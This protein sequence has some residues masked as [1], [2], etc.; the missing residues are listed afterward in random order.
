MCVASWPRDYIVCVWPAPPP[1]LHNITFT[2]QN[3]FNLL[4]LSANAS[5]T[6]TGVV[7]SCASPRI[8][9]TRTLP[10]TLTYSQVQQCTSWGDPHI[11]TFD[12]IYYGF[13]LAGWGRP[14]MPAYIWRAKV[15]MGLFSPVPPS[16]CVASQVSLTLCEASLE[17]LWCKCLSSHVRVASHA[18]TLSS[19]SMAPR[20]WNTRQAQCKLAPCPRCS[21]CVRRELILCPFPLPAG[22]PPS[23]YAFFPTS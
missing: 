18:T 23:P 19:S 9:L 2:A 20:S 17:T 6:S 15:L 3:Y 11:T 16:S 12:G 4:P 5:V 7:T 14:Y 22:M 21:L 1:Q 10:I 8:L 13:Q